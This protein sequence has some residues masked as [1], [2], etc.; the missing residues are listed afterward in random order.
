MIAR[1]ICEGC[2]MDW[3]TPEEAQAC[4]KNHPGQIEFAEKV[5]INRI[6][7]YPE[8]GKPRFIYLQWE[9]GQ[10]LYPSNCAMF[11]LCEFWGQASP[12]PSRL[13]PRKTIQELKAARD[14]KGG[15]KDRK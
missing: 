14:E 4:E 1:F 6:V 11:E 8:S 15:N 7:F 5:V 13:M 12:L 2:L 10:A 3:E 9:N